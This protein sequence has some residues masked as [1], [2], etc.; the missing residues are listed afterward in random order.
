MSENAYVL[1]LDLVG[2][3]RLADRQAATDAVQAAQQTVNARYGS[4]WLAPLETTRGDETAAVLKRVD[5]AWDVIVGM[6]DAIHPMSLRAVLKFGELVAGL[7]TGHATIIDGP[8][9]HRADELMESLKGSPQLLLIETELP[10]LDR[11]LNALGNLLLT[12][13]TDLTKLQRDILRLYQAERLQKA[14]GKTLGRSQQ[15][16]STTLQAIRWQ[17]I[18]NAET[19]MRSL[20]ERLQL[21]QSGGTEHP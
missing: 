14:V 4:A 15:Q 6:A 20:L 13:L 2:S 21:E 16:I 11:T 1:L 12:Q 19:E 17:V 8:A 9:F 3:S 10:T 18:D 7:E 5:V